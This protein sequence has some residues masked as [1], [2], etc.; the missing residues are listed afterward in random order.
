MKLALIIGGKRVASP[1]P[2]PQQA[3]GGSA[4]ASSSASSAGSAA[5]S[6]PVLNPEQLKAV[7][8]TQRRATKAAA[9]AALEPARQERIAAATVVRRAEQASDVAFELTT[10]PERRE[11]LRVD[12]EAPLWR[13]GEYVRVNDCTDPGIDRREG[14]GYVVAVRGVGEDTVI[15]V[16]YTAGDGGCTYRGIGI[17]DA[18]TASLF[19]LFAGERS[20][21]KRRA[22]R[23]DIPIA[24][25]TPQRGSE[26]A[27]SPRLAL[28]DEL[29]SA[30]SSGRG[31]GWRRRDL[32]LSTGTG[33]R[34]IALEKQ[35]LLLEAMLLEEHIALEHTNMHCERY[36]GHGPKKMRFTK[37][38]T[39]HNPLTMKY[40]VE[41]SWG[42]SNRYLAR[43]RAKV[44]KTSVGHGTAVPITGMVEKAAAALLPSQSVIENREAAARTF[45]ARTLYVD[46]YCRRTAAIELDSI[47]REEYGLRRAKGAALWEASAV[48]ERR[49]WDAKARAHVERQPEINPLLVAALKQ[50]PA[51]SWFRLSGVINN[52]CSPSAIQRWMTSHASYSNYAEMIIPLLSL[53]QKVKHLAFARR[54]RANWYRGGGKFLLINYDEK[55]FWG[56][57]LRAAAKECTELGLDPRSFETFHKS[58][59][60]KV[61]AIAFTAFAFIDSMENGGIGLKLAFV[62][63]EGAKI[64]ARMQRASRKTDTGAVKYDGPVVRQKD[65]IYFTDCTITGTDTGTSDKPKFALFSLFRDIIVPK[66][67]ALVAPG[68]QFAGYQVVLQGDQAGPHEEGAFVKS[69][70]D[71][72]TPLGWLLEP[73]APQMPHANNLDLSVFPA[74]SKRHSALTRESGG[75]K[76]LKPDKIWAAA[77]DVYRDLPS[78]KIAR[79]YVQAHRLMAKVIAEKGGNS[80]VGKGCNGMSCG[81]S[82]DFHDTKDGIKR[83]DDKV[84]APP[85]VN[86]P[87]QAERPHVRY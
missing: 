20:E 64:A 63:A 28:V 78:C 62:R 42:L 14:C 60:D 21:R 57:V 80:F 73:Q 12:E 48:A 7:K 6:A 65:D 32:N 24:S 83:K 81:I 87:M 40:L 38:S 8:T 27:L 37:R 41:Y 82:A 34:L 15:D 53:P 67:Q 58:H 52:W 46:A 71:L 72:I 31:G 17:D 2:P 47:D 70:L 25:E 51:S 13:L 59:I 22:S 56:L 86:V 55:W 49:L 23:Q 18:V 74:M 26:A 68:G 9:R 45:T 54:L 79:G 19:S 76:V 29:V 11:G 43:L 10:A 4:A 3:S 30:A 50:N 69:L 66:V 84:V 36:R 1:P 61:M 35:Q 33:T 16:Q 75:T 5:A 44:Q 85:V 77:M 39:L